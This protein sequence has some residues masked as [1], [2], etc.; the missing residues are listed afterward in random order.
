VKTSS[1]RE[2]L[3]PT[4]EIAKARAKIFSAKLRVRELFKQLEYPP[5]HA[6]TKRIA[7]KKNHR[8]GRRR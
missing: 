4:A 3:R 7:K 6:N 2:K 8:L 1:S 5:P